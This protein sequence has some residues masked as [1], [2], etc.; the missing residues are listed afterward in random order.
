MDR[1]RMRRKIECVAIAL[2]IGL[3]S[4]VAFARDLP[5]PRKA[6]PARQDNARCAALGAGFV[7]VPGSQTCVKVGGYVR[8]ETQKSVGGR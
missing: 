3:T 4:T 7:A 5:L 8:V 6:E 1:G 2:T